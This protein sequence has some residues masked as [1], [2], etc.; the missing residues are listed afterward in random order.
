MKTTMETEIWL[1]TEH[2][3]PMQW[4][5][6]KRHIRINIWG[7]WNRVEYTE[8]S[9]YL[10]LTDFWQV[11]V[12]QF[13]GEEYRSLNNWCCDNWYT[14]AKEWSWTST[15]YLCNKMSL[16]G[17]IG[18]NLRIKACNLLEGKHRVIFSWPWVRQWIFPYS[19]INKCSQRKK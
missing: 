12:K 8:I 4:F 9:L 7:K 11:S 2:W 6:V 18:L 3:G 10:P 13:N 17:W 15:C 16:K 19:I 1:P 14:Y 5:T